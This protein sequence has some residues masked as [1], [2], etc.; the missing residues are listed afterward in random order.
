M[1]RLGDQGGCRRSTLSSGWSYL[2]VPPSDAATPLAASATVHWTPAAVPGSVASSALSHDLHALDHWYR[3]D[4]K[5]PGSARLECGGLATLAEIWIDGALVATSDTMFVPLLVDIPR[6]GGSRLEI[7]FRALR[8]VLRRRRPGR[9]PRWLGRLA[10]EEGLRNYRTTLLGHMPGWSGDTPVIGPFRP[11]V[12][13][14]PVAGAPSLTRADMRACLMPNGEGLISVQLSGDGLEGQAGFIT[15]AGHSVELIQSASGVQAELIIPDPPLWWP[16]THGEPL[17]CTVTGR[18]GVHPIDLG[19]IGFRT[20]ERRDAAAGFGLLING[21]PVFCRGAI[22]T[23]LDPSALPGDPADLAST[24]RHAREA[25]LNMLRVTGMTVYETPAFMSLCDELGIMIWHDF[26]LTRFDYPDSP[27]FEASIR[28]EARAFLDMGQAHP[29]LTVLCGGSEVAQAA[30]MAGSPHA[31]WDMPLLERA[32]AEEAAAIRPDVPYVPHAPWSGAANDPPD[33]PFAASASI[34]HYFGVGAYQRP[35]DDLVSANVRFAAEGLAFANLPE[36]ASCRET[37]DG[38]QRAPRD[39]GAEWDFA[40]VRDHYVQSLFE[41]DP[42]LLRRQDVAAWMDLGRA[43]IVLI[44]QQ[45]IA[46]WRTDGRCAGALILMLQDVVPG[47]GWGL[48]GN[49]GRPKSA[50]YALRSVCQPIQVILRDLGQNGVTLYAVNETATPRHL[51]LVLRGLSAEG[52][53]ETLGEVVFPLDARATRTFAATALMGRWRDIANAWKFGPPAFS[54]LGATLDDAVT[55]TRLSDAVCFP[56]GPSLPR[57]QL[58]LTA[59]VAAVADGWSLDVSTQS[60]AQFVQIDDDQC[61]PA[62]NYFHLW[63]GETR[64]V[65]LRPSHRRKGAPLGTVGALNAFESARY[66]VAA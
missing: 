6:E 35:L 15:A 66:G 29:C 40:D 26:M 56:S 34:A 11:I 20:I 41:V 33:L 30:A 58:G 60:F 39:L 54:V 5:L 44:M 23:G 65:A 18:I 8:P 46:T 62:D 14:E 9:R 61:T 28:A 19:R 4:V 47:A 31:A 64:V 13:H 49:D 21:T 2:T 12:L 50:F 38:R 45:A 52:A 24:L 1:A 36:P 55:G 10:T 7:C 32:L 57:S 48:I 37:S 17:T 22:W 51:R 53:V 43:T 42:V 3:L 27:E 59:S 63:P 25:G 16:H